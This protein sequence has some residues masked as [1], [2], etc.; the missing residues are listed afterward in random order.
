[1][2]QFQLRLFST[3]AVVI[4]ATQ[5][6]PKEQVAGVQHHASKS[7]KPAHDTNLVA[8]DKELFCATGFRPYAGDLKGTSAVQE[9]TSNIGSAACAAKCEQRAGCT[10]FEVGGIWP[11]AGCW[12][13][14]GESPRILILM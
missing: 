7:T 8:T 2:M 6:L 4:A 1:M 3:L 9:S 10:G 11:W 13:Y 12:T 5:S 14:T